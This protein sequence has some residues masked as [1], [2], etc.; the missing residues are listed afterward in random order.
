MHHTYASDHYKL[1]SLFSDDGSKIRH[2]LHL[3]V[4]IAYIG[5]LK[6]GYVIDHKDANVFNNHWTNLQQITQAENVRRS[7]EMKNRKGALCTLPQIE[8]TC[9]LMNEGI[10]SA[11]EIANKIGIPDKDFLRYRQLLSAIKFGNSYKDI[12]AKYNV[13]NYNPGRHQLSPNQKAQV[14]AD[15]QAGMKM[16]DLVAKYRVDEQ[17]LHRVYK[18]LPDVSISKKAYS[19]ETIDA[20][21]ADINA[22]MTYKALRGKY[23]IGYPTIARIKRGDYFKIIP[24][25]ENQK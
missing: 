5:E 3:F 18:D 9:K 20:I 12:A 4:Y 2:T 8:E 16:K 25:R 7:F 11:K 22:G 21:I 13:K 15:V 10:Y 14:I 24:R 6:P 23:G 19:K 1:I 17:V